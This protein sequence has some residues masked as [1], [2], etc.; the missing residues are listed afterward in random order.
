M[1]EIE[2]KFLVDRA[3]IRFPAEH[4]DIRQWYLVRADDRSLRVR[5]QEDTFVMTLKVGK[6]AV[7][8]EIEREIL[9]EEAHALI[10]HALEDPIEK[11]RYRI[12]V[13]DHIW[14]VDVFSGPNDG[15]ILAE[16]E[17]RDP[18]EFF[19]RPEWL[20]IEVTGDPKFLNSHLADHP[21]NGWETDFW[22]DNAEL[23][24]EEKAD[25]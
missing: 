24:S 2:R 25:Q 15:L 11:R 1:L 17:L 10:P 7:R 5:E 6:G 18:D 22:G 12:F 23:V 13:K 9:E 16:I 19:A 4:S 21:V 20:G 8:Y 3:I 14:D